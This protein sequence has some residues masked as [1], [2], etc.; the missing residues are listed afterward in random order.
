MA[1]L[2]DTSSTPPTYT[3]VVVGVPAWAVHGG[4]PVAP[5]HA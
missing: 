4:V 5:E 2:V 3:V 1:P